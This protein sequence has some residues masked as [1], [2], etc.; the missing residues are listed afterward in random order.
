MTTGCSSSNEHESRQAVTRIS[1]SFY[2]LSHYMHN[3]ICILETIYNGVAR[4][5]AYVFITAY[6]R[7]LAAICGVVGRCF[8]PILQLS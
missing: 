6:R 4:L 2:D 7:R 1:Y 5:H 8:K 3:S